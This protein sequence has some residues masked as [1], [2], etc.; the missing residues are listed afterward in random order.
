[1]YNFVALVCAVDHKFDSKYS[2]LYAQVQKPVSNLPALSSS[3]AGGRTPNTSVSQ[4]GVPR[5]GS[6]PEETVLAMAYNLLKLCV[7][8]I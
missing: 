1:M 7:S 6:I 3:S 8:Y 4:R 5:E 2:A